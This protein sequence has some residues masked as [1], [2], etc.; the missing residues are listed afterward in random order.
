MLII[1]SLFKIMHWPGANIILAISI[2]LLI[3]VFFPAAFISCYRGNGK[4][5]TALYVTA[6]F[7]LFFLFLSA[8][9]KI[10]HWEG[11]SILLLIGILFPIVVFL[12]V[13]LYF[14]FKEKEESL[15]NFLYI[16]FFL[17]GLSAMS[18]FLA[19]DISKEMLTDMTRITDISDLSAYYKLKNELSKN[20]TN[21]EEIVNQAKLLL[22]KINKIK[23]DLVLTTEDVNKRALTKYNTIQVWEIPNTYGK[24]AGMEILEAQG[25]GYYLYEGVNRFYSFLISIPEIST[26]KSLVHINDLPDLISV[27]HNEEKKDTW[28]IL[29]ANIPLILLLLRLTEVENIIRLAELEAIN[30]VSNKSLISSI[31]E[32]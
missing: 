21:V 14:H 15:V 30:L 20:D 18:G 19:I 23:I 22:D 4:K 13:Y 9:F 5:Q 32:I 29:D 28:Y 16:I 7:T 8:A 31:K 3:F 26:C 27:K 6:F 25:K 1:G 12:P 24:D 10:M 2:A 17:V 11:A